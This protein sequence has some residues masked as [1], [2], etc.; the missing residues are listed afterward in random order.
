MKQAG[1]AVIRYD[2]GP[3]HSYPFDAPWLTDAQFGAIYDR[4]RENTL[5]DR[6]RCY[7]LFR[8]AKQVRDV[9]GNILEVGVWRGGTTALLA[10]TR[11]D[12]MVFAADTFAGVV[13]A[14][15]WEHYTDG[16]HADADRQAVDSFLAKLGLSN[17][18]ILEG[19]FPDDTGGEVEDQSFALVH[20]D[21]DVYLSARD[22]LDF[23][24]PRLS[25]SGV[26]VLDDYGFVS[27]CV[28]VHRLGEE[29][30]ERNDNLFIASPNGQGYIIKR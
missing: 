29:W 28:G 5:V 17:V 15:D 23:I 19:V 21:V 7:S 14:S 26:V 10:H 3:I 9:P 13:K 2:D 24:W 20:I 22:A 4:I 27:A 16:A 12:R 30:A 18:R 1:Y 6:S 11:P 25:P 8:L